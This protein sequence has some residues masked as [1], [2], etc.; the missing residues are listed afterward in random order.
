[1]DRE[2]DGGGLPGSEFPDAVEIVT[3]DINTISFEMDILDIDIDI[4]NR[5]RP[6]VIGRL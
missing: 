3:D 5:C 2:R 6:G 1:M 4:G